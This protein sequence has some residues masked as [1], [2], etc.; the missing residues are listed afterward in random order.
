MKKFLDRIVSRTCGRG[1]TR[2][3]SLLTVAIDEIDLGNKVRATHDPRYFDCD[4]YDSTG[5]DHIIGSDTSNSTDPNDFIYAYRGGADIIEA[6]TGRDKVYAFAGDDVVMGGGD[7]DIMWGGLGNDRIY[8][9]TQMSVAAAI[10]A[11]NVD[12]S[13]LNLQGDW[14]AGGEGNDTLIGSTA[15]D[16]LT[17]GNGTD[18]LI[19]GAG[20]DDILGDSDWVASSFDW[21]VTQT[22]T[23][24]RSFSPVEDL[25]NPGTGAADVIYAGEGNDHV[26]AEFG[27]DVIFGE[28][29]DDQRFE[30]ADGTARWRTC[31]AIISS[32]AANDETANAWRDAA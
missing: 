22:P 26:I 3:I 25:S 17:G 16:V 15:R 6:G 10:V 9:D 12:G 13:G 14:L 4:L 27:N 32:N 30:F 24:H 7:G 19:A 28:G 11:G 5:N 2:E 29:G 18:L 1:T 21:T 31:A 23:A 8:A 20:D